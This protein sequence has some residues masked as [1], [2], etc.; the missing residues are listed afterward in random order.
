MHQ[1]SAHRVAFRKHAPRSPRPD[2]ASPPARPSTVPSPYT[3]KEVCK[4]EI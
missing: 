4:C 1:A 2:A 3:S